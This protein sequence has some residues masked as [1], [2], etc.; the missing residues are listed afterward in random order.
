MLIEFKFSNYRSFRE[1]ACLSME[2]MGLSQKK[3]CLIPY[4]TIHLLPAVAIYG[5][6]GGGKTNVIRAFWLGVKF[7]CNAQ[8]TQHETAPVP[9]RPFL[10]D[11]TA[12]NEP[13]SFEFTYVVN[14]VKYLYGFSATKTEIVREYLY[15]WP[16]GQT[17]MV[18][19]RERQEFTFRSGPD[20]KKRELISETV[21]PNQLYFSVACTFN[22]QTCKSAMLWFREH[23]LFS[24]DYTDLSD[25]LLEYS[26]DPN[27]LRAIKQ[28]AISADL[29]IRDMKFDIKSEELKT[30]DQLPDDLPEEV[31]SSLK[32]FLQA[33]AE[34]PN[35][36]ERNLQMGEL[37][38]SSFHAGLDQAGR[39]CLYSLSLDDESDGTR[40]LMA[41]APAI[42]RVLACG[43]VLLVDELENGIHPLLLQMIVSKFQSP[44]SNPNHGQLVFTT[45][46]AEL[47]DAG[48]LRKDQ[49]YFVDKDRRSGGS[50][51]YGISDFSTP[52]NENLRKGYLLGKY[53]ATPDLE[54][55]EV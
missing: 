32:N 47:L 37:Q 43:G 9:V 39:E 52:T 42:E 19:S 11:D 27:M 51:L 3:R 24:R 12:E 53:G 36:S 18:F 45:H 48:L 46:N 5:K 29:G 16:K 33:L 17:A 22:D 23:L 31:L 50:A 13:T 7:I 28:Y 15:H 35:V 30:A 41:L 40:R 1:E 34:S 20:K 25:Q 54:I 10:L 55:E 21:A 6:N 2:P 4:K 26:E 14:D 8:R 44:D 49:F 38:V